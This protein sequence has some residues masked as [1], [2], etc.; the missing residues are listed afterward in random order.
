MKQMKNRG[1]ESNHSAFCKCLNFNFSCINYQVIDWETR[2]PRSATPLS[3]IKSARLK[4]LYLWQAS[5]LRSSTLACGFVTVSLPFFFFGMLIGGVPRCKHCIY[6]LEIPIVS[7][8][9]QRTS[10]V[11]GGEATPR[12]V[13]WFRGRI[14]ATFVVVACLN[15]LAT[16]F[17]SSYT[18]GNTTI[19]YQMGLLLSVKRRATMPSLPSGLMDWI[20]KTGQHLFLVRL[21]DTSRLLGLFSGCGDK[22]SYL[23]T[24]DDSGSTEG[25]LCDLQMDS[26]SARAFDRSDPPVLY[27]H[28][29]TKSLA[30]FT[31]TLSCLDGTT[32]W[33]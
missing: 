26:H 30:F 9:E 32:R 22:S 14:P 33:R 24:K 2:P 17:L 12:S 6:R 8:I 23:G 19:L 7:A 1:I 13:I 15:I 11:A 25:G 3:S 21:A 27:S 20:V 10:R 29:F 18:L 16:D 31:A 28:D 5:F 4:T